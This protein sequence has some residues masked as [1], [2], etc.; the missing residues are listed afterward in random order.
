[1]DKVNKKPI[2]IARY[3]FNESI[4]NIINS[5]INSDGLPIFVI[6]GVIEDIL[7]ELKNLEIKQL[8][9]DRKEYIAT[10]SNL[11]NTEENVL[12]DPVDKNI[13]NLETI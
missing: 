2:T 6:R 4:V 8:D 9:I 13:E 10:I 3:D 5:F 12:P 7:E 11:Q 1:M